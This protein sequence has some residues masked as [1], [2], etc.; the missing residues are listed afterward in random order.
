MARKAL[1]IAAFAAAFFTP[2]WGAAFE[3]DP[4]TSMARMGM[5]CWQAAAVDEALTIAEFDPVARGLLIA[6]TDPSQPLVTFWMHMTTGRGVVTLSQA[7]GEECII[8]VVEDA[9]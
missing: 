2:T 4:P 3:I 6:K 5:P 7:N 9:H 1:L 8:A